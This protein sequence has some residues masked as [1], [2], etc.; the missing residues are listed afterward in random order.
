MPSFLPSGEPTLDGDCLSLKNIELVDIF[1]RKHASLQ[2]HPSHKY[3]NETLIHHGYLG[4]SPLFPTVAISIRTLAVYWQVH[5]TCPR[6]SIQAQCKALCHL[7]NFSDAYDIYLKILHRVDVLINQALNRDS[8]NLAVDKFKDEVRGQTHSTADTENWQDIEK[9][10]TVPSSFTC[11]DRWR[12]AGPEQRKRMFSVFDE[13]GIFIAACRHWFILL[14]CDM[15]KSGELAKYPLAVVDQLLMVYGKNGGCAFAK[16]LGNSVF[17]RN[18]YRE[19]LAD[20]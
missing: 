2:P 12:N 17:I 5:R 8:P 7:H 4:C 20:I 1:S 16:T 18:H 6:F 13:S 15:V 19:A 3:P 10:E 11:V 9:T 14:A